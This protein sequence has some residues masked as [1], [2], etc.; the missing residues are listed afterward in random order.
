MKLE[1]EIAF[2]DLDAMGHVNNAVYFTF[3]ET[4]RQK[5]W[6]AVFGIRKLHDIAF[7][8]AQARLSY[9]RPL[10]LADHI[11]VEVHCSRLGRS[12][13]DFSYV[14]RRGGEVVAEGDTTQVLWDWEREVKREFTSEERQRIEQFE[15]SAR[16]V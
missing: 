6:D 15:S 16:G 13:F 9:R 11:E 8:V 1:F 3:L 7:V 4:A 5:Y 14:V 2:R 12:S 10:Y